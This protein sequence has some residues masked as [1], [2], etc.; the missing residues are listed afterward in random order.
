MLLSQWRMC[1]YL[2]CV[3]IQ[4]KTLRNSIFSELRRGCNSCTQPIFK[5]LYI[6]PEFFIMSS[7]LQQMLR[8]LYQ[9]VS[10]FLLYSLGKPRSICC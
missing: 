10:L 5:L 4:S 1:T 8:E 6:T 9:A 3:I 7:N 2:Y